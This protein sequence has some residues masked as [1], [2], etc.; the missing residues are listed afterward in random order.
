[1]KHTLIIETDPRGEEVWLV[2]IIHRERSGVSLDFGYDAI[3]YDEKEAREYMVREVSR[4][5]QNTRDMWIRKRPC[6]R[7]KYHFFE[8]DYDCQ[9]DTIINGKVVDSIFGAMSRKTIR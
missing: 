8:D 4:V 7:P 3:F 9:A 1:M 2:K 5:G 6:P